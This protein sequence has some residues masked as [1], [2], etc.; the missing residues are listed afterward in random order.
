M[1]GGP[2]F[3][4]YFSDGLFRH[5]INIPLIRPME[6]FPKIGTKQLIC[7]HPSRF[8]VA[9]NYKTFLRI[10]E[11][12]R[13]NAGQYEPIGHWHIHNAGQNTR[14]TR[15]VEFTSTKIVYSLS[16]S[17][18]ASRYGSLEMMLDPFIG[19]TGMK[20]VTDAEIQAFEPFLRGIDHCEIVEP[21]LS[22]QAYGLQMR[23]ADLGSLMDVNLMT[24][25]VFYANKPKVSFVEIGGGYGRLAEVAVNLLGENC[26]Y[27]LIDSVPASLMF[28]YAYLKNVLPKCKIG[29]FYEG[30]SYSKDFQIF[31]MPSWHVDEIGGMFDLAINIESFQEMAPRHLD[32]YIPMLSRFLGPGAVLYISNSWNYIYRGGFSIPDDFQTLYL[33]NTPRSWTHVHPTHILRKGTENFSVVNRAMLEFFRMSC[34]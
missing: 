30:D 2:N 19:Q 4:P 9:G 14:N 20:L 13:D 31:I 23:L 33:Q 28:A 5:R 18:F 27:L 34:G 11:D 8:K 16:E 21:D 32:L 3:E 7:N 12:L 15:D 26:H 24:G 25:H 10:A 6:R 29:S 1:Y 22:S 17:E